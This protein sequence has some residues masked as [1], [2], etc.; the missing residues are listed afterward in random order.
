MIQ[1]RRSPGAESG[2]S[3]KQLADNSTTSV[4]LPAARANAGPPC[5]GRSLWAVTVL[6][7]PC[8]GGMHQHRAGES[9]GLLSG[10]VVR[11][12]PATGERY[13]LAPVRRWREA[14]RG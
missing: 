4:N 1:K 3:T 10:R 11:A 6:S 13:R 7:C 8:C 14:R 12:C 5:R 2:A 9:S